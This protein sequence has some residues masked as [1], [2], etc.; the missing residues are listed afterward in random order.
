MKSSVD[1]MGVTVLIALLVGTAI[2]GIPGALVAVPTAAI[3]V[4]FANEYLV[5]HQD[6]DRLSVLD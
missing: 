2:S 1:L 5:Q 3:V 4:V 6:P